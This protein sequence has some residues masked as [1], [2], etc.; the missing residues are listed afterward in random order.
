M[1]HNLTKSKSNK[2][3]CRT[4]QILSFWKSWLLLKNSGSLQNLWHLCSPLG[5][6]FSWIT[7]PWVYEITGAYQGAYS[8]PD[9]IPFTPLDSTVCDWLVSLYWTVW[10]FAHID[11]P[12]DSIQNYFD[13]SGKAQVHTFS[14]SKLW[15]SGNSELSSFQIPKEIFPSYAMYVILQGALLNAEV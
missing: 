15:D 9:G 10:E 12:H 3:L 6:Q 1:L 14:C 2:S 5:S 13:F 4:L 11:L 7:R 8:P